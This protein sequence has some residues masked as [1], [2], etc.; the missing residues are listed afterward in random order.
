V[1]K[2]SCPCKDRSNAVRAGF[3]SFLVDTEMTGNR[4]MGSFSFDGFSIRAHLYTQQI[5]IVTYLY[6]NVKHGSLKVHAQV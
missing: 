6:E 2:S 4:A 3:A 1:G 5:G